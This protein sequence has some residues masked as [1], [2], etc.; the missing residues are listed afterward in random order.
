MKIAYVLDSSHIVPESFV[1]NEIAE[2]QRRGH[3]IILVPLRFPSPEERRIAA[4]IDVSW[5][6][7]DPKP[8]EILWADLMEIVPYG[9]CLLTKVRRVTSYVGWRHFLKL[10]WMA[11][12]L[13]TE[14]VERIHAHF[15]LTAGVRAMVLS[16][17]LGIPFSCTGHGSDILIRRSPYLRDMIQNAHPFITISEFNRRKLLQEIEEIEEDQIVVIHCGVDLDRFHPQ[18]RPEK[19]RSVLLSVT[20]LIAIKG[21]AYLLDA[22][23]LLKANKRDFEWIVIG[24]KKDEALIDTQ[25]KVDKRGLTE[26]MK[27][28]RWIPHGEVPQYLQDADI[29]VLPSLSEGIPVS[30]MEAMAM[31]LPVVA[32]RITGIPELVKDGTE[33]L[34]VEPRNAQAIAEKVEQLMDDT[35]LRRKLG[36]A[37]RKKVEREFALRANVAKLEEA[38]SQKD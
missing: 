21:I 29:F 17:I 26:V 10:L 18:K 38:F 12:Q 11:H 9:L 6:K 14:N 35:A 5:I 7:E 1:R 2:L 31:E 8:Y 23:S 37:A 15:A 36:R 19:A 25:N 28:V 20:E 32:T 13:R 4:R 33:G 16:R 34:L 3:Q 24:A 30:L 27:I 22:C